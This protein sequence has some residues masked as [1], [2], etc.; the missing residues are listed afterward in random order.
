MEESEQ[1]KRWKNEYKALKAKL[2]EA[3]SI[4]ETLYKADNNTQAKE[5]TEKII[6]YMNQRSRIN[7]PDYPP[8][9]DPILTRDRILGRAKAF[10]DDY[11]KLCE[12]HEVVLTGCSLV[13]VTIGYDEDAKQAHKN[14]LIKSINFNPLNFD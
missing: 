12:L 13:R 1:I 4:L 10:I 3:E 11:I 2:N 6:N 14:N 8:T 7:K 5:I 9:N